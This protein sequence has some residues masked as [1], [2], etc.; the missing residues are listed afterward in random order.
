MPP[1]R[2]RQLAPFSG[3]AS[4]A[5]HSRLRRLRN[6][7]LQG[8]VLAPMLFNIY[9][10]D[11]PPT[12]AKKYGYADDLAILLSDKRWETIEEGFTA[13]MSTLS[14]YLKNCP[15]KLSVA[16]TMSSSFH[17]NNREARRELKVMVDG[18]AMQFKATPTHPDLQTT[19]GEDVIENNI[20]RLSDTLPRRNHRGSR[21]EDPLHLHPGSGLLRRRLLCTGLVQH[22]KKLDVALNNSLRTVSGSLRANSVNHLSILSG[23]TPAALRREA[24]VL[25]LAHKAERDTDHLLHKTVCEPPQRARLKSCHTFAGHAYQLLR[26]MP[27][28]TSKQTWIRHRWY[29]EWRGVANH[30]QLHKFSCQMRSP[31]PNFPAGNG[32]HSTASDPALT[33]LCP[34]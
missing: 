1:P 33:D 16:K 15:L 6:G 31:V 30:S 34:P 4:D 29:E 18:N 19:P 23:I 8:S 3:R 27:P 20:P 25:V 11:L 7:I 22:T 13:D 2:P 5:E 12:L 14:T 32:Q 26:D 10:H 17:L 21:N 24:A 28:D 9:V